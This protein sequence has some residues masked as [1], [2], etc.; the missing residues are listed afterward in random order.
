MSIKKTFWYVL[1]FSMVSF[2]GCGEKDS[3]EENNQSAETAKFSGEKFNE[4]IRSTPARTPEEERLGFKL[5]EG[6]E[7]ELFAS[8]PEIGKPINIS[9]DAKGRMW[10]TQSYEY[11]FPA[12]GQGK[13]KITI[14]ED[15]DG[16]GKADLFTQF[17]DTLNIPLGILPMTDGAVAYSIPNIY[18]FTD[19]DKVGKADKQKTLLG[20]FQH[21]DTHGMV[22]NFIRG[23][24]GWIHACHGFTNE[25]KVAGADGDSIFMVSGNTFRFKPDGS[26]VEH[27]THG[28]INPF[29]LAYD[30]WG[31]LYSTDCH[32][33]PLYQL[34]KGGEYYQWGREE[35]MGFAPDMKPLE[36]EATALAGIAYYADQHF[37][38]EFQHNFY[39]GDVVACRVYRNSFEFKGSSPVG[40]KEDDFIL[41]EDPWFRPVDVKL[42]PDGA[43][44]IAD[45]YNSII[46]HYEVPLEHPKRDKIRGR[47]WRITY[48]GAKNEK[49]DWS[50]APLNDLI[51]ALDADNLAVRMTA[52]DQLVDR[53]GQPAVAAVKAMY[54]K[55]EISTRK[56]IHGLW[57]L[58]RLNGLD[59]ELIKKSLAQSEPVI[60]VHTLGILEERE[61]N[62]K[63]FYPLILY[64]LHDKDPHVQRAAVQLLVRYATIETLE[65]A[66]AFRKEIP[67]YDSHMI[68]ATR[69][70]IR[71]LVR[72]EALM[73]QVLASDWEQEDAKNL[74]DVMLGVPSE[75]AGLFLAGYLNSSREE[76]RMKDKFQHAARFMPPGQLE[77]F[78]RASMENQGKHID[79]EFLKFS[80]IRQ[81]IEQRGGAEPI[82]MQQWGKILA[83][84]ILKN[85]SPEDAGKSDEVR[86]RQLF[87][88]DLAGDYKIRNV[89]P[90]LKAFVAVREKQVPELTTAALNALLKL[91]AEANAVL[92]KSLITDEAVPENLKIQIAY[93][94]GDFPGPVVNEVLEAVENPSPELQRAIVMSMSNS[95][96]GLANIFN[97]VRSGELFPRILLDPKVEERIAINASPRHQKEFEALTADLDPVSKEKEMLLFNRLENFRLNRESLS[98]DSG[99]IV[100]AQH[101]STCHQVAN[102]GGKIGPQLDGVGKWGER[103]LAEKILDPNRNISEAF[104]TYTIKLKDSKVMTGLYRR[105]EGEVIVF[106]DIGGNEFS[107]PKKDIAEQKASKYT[108][109][110]DHFGNVLSEA[111]FNNLVAYLLNLKS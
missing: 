97:K 41:S 75:G 67:D 16:D 23:Y 4:H 71:N 82:Q 107:V 79:S 14:L 21:K 98:A 55:K 95:P 10:V 61:V 87:A 25:S 53:I 85:Y 100:F 8:E 72:N 1:Y 62:G 76:Y 51:A 22:N 63:D 102:E 26:R 94:L 68:Y 19:T 35:G 81:G 64:A 47:I 40:K 109:M 90:Q 2:I 39:I 6:F 70:S 104:R 57:V 105:D 20:P 106:A 7:I 91:D 12:E 46:G 9:F 108:L 65:T 58:Q 77:E 99:H 101:C 103:A 34:I 49:V 15:T 50:A 89:A 73:E 37:P 111:E 29:G 45:F 48:K 84:N 28:R 86:I 17:N 80:G 66:L 42:G 96:E 78:I 44:Y 43:L 93:L 13:D 92:A 74:A 56:Y 69:L 31:Y 11:P 110:P 88:I 60:K 54:N 38:K 18:R 52:A 83:V 30:E 33:S 59:E 24:D 3:G 36:D 27:M 5:P 32:T